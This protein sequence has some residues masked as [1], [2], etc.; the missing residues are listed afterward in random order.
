MTKIKNAVDLEEAPLTE[1]KVNKRLVFWL[2][3][4][5][6]FVYDFKQLYS[7]S[8]NKIDVNMK[9]NVFKIFNW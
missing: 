5:F 9:N 3:K 7:I 6:Q 4:L 1:K 8:N 2:A